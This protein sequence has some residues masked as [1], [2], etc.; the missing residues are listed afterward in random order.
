MN[1]RQQRL[2]PP[3]VLLLMAAIP[4]RAGEVVIEL[5]PEVMVNS[6]RITLADLGR[7]DSQ[8]AVVQ[9]QLAALPVGQA[10]MVGYVDQRDRSALDV[11]LHGQAAM[12]GQSIVWRGA[13][14]VKI[15]R[16]SQALDA[17]TLLGV[18]T[19]LVRQRFGDDVEVKLDDA[20]RDLGAP[21]GEL[22]YAARMPASSRLHARLPV[23]V[24]I[25]TQDGLYR[26]VVLSLLVSARREVY[27]ARR[28][29]PAGSVVAAG[30]FELR[31]EDIAAL[32][33]EALVS[34]SLDGGGR[35]RQ[36]LAAGEIATTRQLAP[37]SMILR[38]D[39]VLL[40]TGAAGIAIETSAYAESNAIMGQA[41]QVR[42]AN[43]RETVVARVT[44]PGEVSM[45]GR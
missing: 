23:W 45:D 25:S 4:V 40:K 43:S 29:L 3:L 17:G 16:A 28:D 31:R 12:L 35:L 44:G 20:W 1:S 30:D 41:L 27:V 32:P 5:H 34:G 37:V 6:A 2:L 33:D 26:S 38:G 13:Q 14:V 18:A 36:L 39:Q 19:Q 42:P 8:D 24:D 15:R 22:H 7:V 10:P 9:R 11:Q 21:A